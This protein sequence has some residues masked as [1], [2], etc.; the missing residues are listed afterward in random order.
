[1]FSMLLEGHFNI[2][3]VKANSS[4]P[5][6]LMKRRYFLERTSTILSAQLKRRLAMKK[7]D[8]TILSYLTK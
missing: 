7:I 6:Y 4:Y 8:P 1:M 5:F 2:E 3:N